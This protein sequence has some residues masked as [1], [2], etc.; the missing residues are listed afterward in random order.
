MASDLFDELYKKNQTALTR[1]QRNGEEK[2]VRAYAEVLDEIRKDL[3][4]S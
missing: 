3:M 2:L 4:P 1:L